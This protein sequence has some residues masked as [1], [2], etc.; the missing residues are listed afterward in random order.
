M[1]RDVGLALETPP[2]T[3]LIPTLVSIGVPLGFLWFVRR[4]DLYASGSFRTVLVCFGAG[5]AAFPAAYV[6]NTQAR[7]LMLASGLTAVAASLLLRTTVAPIIEEVLKSAGVVYYANKPQFTYFVDGAIYGFAAGTAFAVIEN[8]NYLQNA[9]EGLALGT[10]INRAFSTS[11]M[12]GGASALVGVAIGR[13]RFE[14][15][16]TRAFA[17]V[18]GWGAAI[19]LHSA[20]NRLVN[21]G[22]MDTMR[23]IGAFGI[24][25]GAVGL[26]ALFILWGLRV[27]RRWLRQS[28]GLDVGVT[29]GESEV[30]QKLADLDELL[31]PITEVFGPQKRD[32]VERF[33]RIQ[34][35]LGIKRKAQ[36]LTPDAKLAAALAAE[37]A[38]LREEMDQLRREVGVYC[39]TF[40]R[41][42]LP[43]ETE[44]LWDPLAKRLAEVEARRETESGGMNLWQTLGDRADAAGDGAAGGAFADSDAAEDDA[45]A[46]DAAAG[47]PST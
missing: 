44:A 10:A 3:L 6:L 7:G 40:V 32:A 9:P 41:S 46:G 38:D 21:S 27:Q 4:M 5:L 31:R 23:L 37:V 39:M 30:V 28:L 45:T 11:L 16:W 12:H 20:F 36:Q 26:T 13:F 22:P 15:G 47:D 2:L 43:P 35:R 17:L 1:P 29:S 33:L 8:V 19:A 34:A 18:G 25:F 14:K 42:I 24:G